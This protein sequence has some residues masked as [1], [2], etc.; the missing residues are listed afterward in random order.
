MFSDSNARR[1]SS[2]TARLEVDDRVHSVSRSSRIPS[3][4]ASGHSPRLP[5]SVN[6]YKSPSVFSNVNEASERNGDHLKAHVG[7]GG[8]GGG[9]SVLGAVELPRKRRALTVLGGLAVG[10]LL[11]AAS[12]GTSDLRDEGRMTTTMVPTAFLPIIREGGNVIH[13]ISPAVGSRVKTWHDN[14]IAA[15]EAQGEASRKLS[16]EEHKLRS[17]HTFHPNGLLLVNENGRHPIYALIERAEQRWSDKLAKQSRTLS[18][19]VHEYK[20][21]YRRNPPKGFDDWWKFCEENDVQLRDEYDQIDKDLLP[22]RALEPSDSRHRNGVMQERGHTFTMVLEPG[23]KM[24]GIKGEYADTRRAREI[25]GLLSLFA[26]RVSRNLNLTYIIDD[27]PAVLLPYSER[28]RMVELAEQGEYWGPSEFVSTDDS[29]LSNFAQAC[30]PDSPLR[31]SERGEPYHD[32]SSDTRKTFVWDHPKSVDLCIHPEGRKA[33]GHLMQQGVPPG[34]LVPLL[35]FAKTSMQADILVTPMEQWAENYKEYEPPWEGKSENKLL[36][37]GSTTG[38]EFDRHTPW[39]NS[40]RARL[41]MMSQYMDGSKEVLWATDDKMHRGNFTIEDMNHLYM[42]TF[43]SG[44]PAQCDPETCEWLRKNFHFKPTIGI[45]ESNTYKYLMDVDGNGWSG[46]FHRLMSTR[47]VVLKATAFP[48][49][50][51]ERIEPWVH[52]VPVKL[53]YS[54]LYDTMTFFV[55][56]PQ[57]KGAHDAL[58]QKIGAAGQKWAA[59]HWR[60]ADMAAYMYRLVLE[61]SRILALDLEDSVDYVEEPT[62]LVEPDEPSL[63]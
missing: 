45:E 18:E 42:D 48:E 51:H 4:V 59:T 31:R 56:T 29:H 46:R 52:Y 53:D 44:Q 27:N 41:H 22:H 5:F 10:Y 7:A 55:G 21:R 26:D 17:Q 8:R 28:S 23:R 12:K 14:Q 38:A 13:R 62:F 24:A 32:Y 50:Y 3:G 2:A 35:T 49:W 20:N 36:W 58:A 47:S 57:G 19:A 63:R 33:H 54:D 25:Q 6:D 60:K 34:P 39:R 9:R 1:R 61:Y 43:F 37:R 40:Q 15:I 30:A 11:L 16:E